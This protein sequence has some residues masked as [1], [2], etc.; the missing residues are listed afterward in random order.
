MSAIDRRPATAPSPSG[1]RAAAGVAL[2]RRSRRP[3]TPQ[4]H[5]RV[6]FALLGAVRHAHAAPGPALPTAE[7]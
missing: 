3:P 6:D 5:E 1:A 7:R 2:R 4:R